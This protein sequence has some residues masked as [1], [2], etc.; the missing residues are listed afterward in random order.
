MCIHKPSVPMGRWT[1]ETGDSP[2][3]HRPAWGKQPGVECHLQDGLT[4]KVALSP[5]HMPGGEPPSPFSEQRSG[6]YSS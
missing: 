2:G 5:L 3:A 4:P 1:A 6:S